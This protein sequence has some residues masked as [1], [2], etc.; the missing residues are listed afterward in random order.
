MTEIV[1]FFI[2]VFYFFI[3]TY[4]HEKKGVFC[5]YSIVEGQQLN[6]KDVLLYVLKFNNIVAWL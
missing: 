6:G 4:G 5:Y 2:T 1:D 3:L